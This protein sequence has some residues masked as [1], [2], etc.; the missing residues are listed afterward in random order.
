MSEGIKAWDALESLA[1]DPARVHEIEEQSE[2]DID[3]QVM[4]ARCSC[5]EIIYG[6]GPS[7]LRRNIESHITQ[8]ATDPVRG[9]RE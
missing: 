5:G 1:T 8:R 4:E 2:W 9:E 3:G 6:E 7:I